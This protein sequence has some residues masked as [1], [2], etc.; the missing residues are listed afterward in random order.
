MVDRF[1][2]QVLSRSLIPS[3]ARTFTS[4][5][6]DTAEIGLNYGTGIGYRDVDA[7]LEDIVPLH[8]HVRERGKEKE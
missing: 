7:G 1:R 8:V 5:E 2:D 4:E 3:P 6:W